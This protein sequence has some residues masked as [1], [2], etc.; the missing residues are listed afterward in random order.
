MD[1]QP[2]RLIQVL[3]GDMALIDPGN[4]AAIYPIQRPGGLAGS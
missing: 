1:H 3:K 2:D 4:V